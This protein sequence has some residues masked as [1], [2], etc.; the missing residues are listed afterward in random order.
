MPDKS[1]LIV[2][3][4]SK[5]I[6]MGHLI[7]SANAFGVT[8]IVVGKKQLN[9]GGATGRTK[10]TSVVQF[11]TLAEAVDFV[12]GEGC[13]LYGIEIDEGA[14]S[15]YDVKFSGPAAFMIGN[16]GQGLSDKQIAMCDQLVTIPQ[17]G[18]AVSLNVSVACAIVLSRFAEKAGFEPVKI[19]G[20][21]FGK[22]DRT[23]KSTKSVS[24]PE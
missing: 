4:I 24:G 19:E 11:F 18:S 22:P 17:Y 21:K 5:Q 10:F 12:R 20:R 6:N 2:F 23:T 9:R 15:V 8:T 14:V 3:N 13:K 7:R 1:Y 16:E